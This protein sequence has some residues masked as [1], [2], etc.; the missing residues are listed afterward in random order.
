MLP[1]STTICVINL[2]VSSKSLPKLNEE[3]EENTNDHG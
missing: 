1:Q 3:N 2:K